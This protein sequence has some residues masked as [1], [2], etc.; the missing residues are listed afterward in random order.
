MFFVAHTEYNFSSDFLRVSKTVKGKFY[1]ITS[2]EG[3]TGELI[4]SSILS[5]TSAPRPGSS[6][7]RNDPVASKWHT[8]C[9]FSNYMC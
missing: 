8:I 7:H 1:P 6:T 9:E 2:H 5:L 4:Y 3:T